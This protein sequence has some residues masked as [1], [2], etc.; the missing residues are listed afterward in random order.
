ML[1][2]ICRAWLFG[3][4]LTLGFSMFAGE[5]RKD[6]ESAFSA[7]L[8][9]LKEIAETCPQAKSYHEILIKFSMAVEKYRQRV[10]GE[11]RHT[12]QHYMDQILI[13]E[14]TQVNNEQ[15]QASQ[16]GHTTAGSWIASLASEDLS[17]QVSG[18]SDSAGAVETSP[19]WE[20][21]NFQFDSPD[22]VEELEELERLFYSVE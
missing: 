19:R 4:G 5:P 18:N 7:I 1:K 10:E 14:S 15:I 17:C 21:F 3:S 6:I 13:I 16:S 12:V 2:L 9:L 11:V 8:G 20:D 22:L